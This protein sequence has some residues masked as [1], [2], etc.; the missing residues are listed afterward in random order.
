MAPLTLSAPKAVQRTFKFGLKSSLVFATGDFDQVVAKCRLDRAQHFV[1]VAAENDFVEFLNHLPRTE[2][3]EVTS[4]FSGRAGR[5]F[6]SNGSEI[7]TA[8]NLGL[9]V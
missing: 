8:F 6:G 3:P 1:Q 7:F 9:K 5:K 2:L 4:R